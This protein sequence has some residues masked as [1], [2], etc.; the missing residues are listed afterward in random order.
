MTSTLGTSAS[1]SSTSP[2]SNLL[3]DKNS[4]TPQFLFVGGKGGVGKTSTSAALA[5]S[6]SN[7]GFRTLI[8]STDPAHSLGDAL[9][10]NLSSGRVTPIVTEPSLWALEIDVEAALQDFKSTA[11]SLDS[12][13]LAANLGIP[14]DIIDSIGI[15]DIASIFTNLPPGIDEIVALTKIFKYA[16]ELQANGKPMYDRIIIDTAP[17]GHTIRLLQLPAFLNSVTGKLL[18]FRAKIS[19]AVNTFKSLFG[20]KDSNSNSNNM[21]LG[22]VLDKIEDLQ[23]SLSRMKSMLKDE[24]RTRFLIVTIP[25]S[26]AVAESKRLV[27]S[28]QEEEVAIAAIVCNQ[29]VPESGGLSYLLTRRRGQQTCLSNLRALADSS[30]GIQLTEVPYFDTEVTGLYGLRF[31]A[32]VAH[33]ILPSAATNPIDSRK[34]TVFGGKGGVGKT[35]SAASWAVQL[36]D[37]GLNVLVVSTD[38]AHSLGDALS[39]PLSGVPRLLDQPSS[40]G[41]LWAMEIDPE[42]ALAEF[43]DV[44][45]GALGDTSSS[46]GGAVGGMGLPDLKGDL[47]DMIS[48][49]N[50]PPPGTDEIVAMAKVVTYL[51]EGLEVNGRKIRF[52]RVVLDTAPTGHTLRMLTLPVFLKGLMQKLKKIRD[53]TGM[54]GSMMGGGQSSGAE[55]GV[56]DR[57]EKFEKRMDRLQAL[58]HN[59]KETEFTVV[60]IPTEL[61][62]AETHR[63]VKAL[64]DQ[65]ILTRRLIVNQV[66]QPQSETDEGASA[67]AYMSRLR[68]GQKQSLSVLNVL[69]SA[70]EVPLMQVPYFDT[71]IRTVYGLRVIGNVILPSS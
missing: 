50:D 4:K 5:V 34:L 2:L 65:K 8:V 41:Q 57:L 38:P 40:G 55:E 22:G 15:E 52:D 27:E 35:T 61:A 48:G 30:S 33:K 19:S 11:A 24:S 69:A 62:V 39:E 9:A 1:P 71:E 59:P 36:S 70:A 47:F 51:E 17:T 46:S 16:D 6:L 64:S 10:E 20:G 28:L 23:A 63:L 49:V 68:Q 3:L 42:S 66:V 54:L 13:S 44:V 56:E 29:V 43:K 67:N 12:S 60:T 18:K 37:A 7:Q 45:Q 32:S 25:T 14:K 26:L 58:L 21:S 31:F 53:K